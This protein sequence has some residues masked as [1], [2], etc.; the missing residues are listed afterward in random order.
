MMSREPGPVPGACLADWAAPRSSLGGSFLCI[1][2]SLRP[3]LQ[4][5][6]VCHVSQHLIHDI[7]LIPV[8]WGRSTQRW[9]PGLPF[10][11]LQCDSGQRWFPPP[12]SAHPAC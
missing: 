4:S 2:D 8:K 10:L 5:F 11:I 1:T 12:A 7:H 9:N 3:S 6:L